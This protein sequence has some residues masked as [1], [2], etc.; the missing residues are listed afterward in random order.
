M[1]KP[2]IRAVEAFP[3]EHE[4]QRLICLRDPLGLAPQPLAM[5]AA[6]YFLL[7]LMDGTR[8][9]GEIGQA[10]AHQFGYALPP[11]QLD[12]FIETLDQ[13]FFLDNSRFAR[14]RRAVGQ[15]FAGLAQRPAAHAGLCYP[16]QPSELR[17][18]LMSFFEPP[19]GPGWAEIASKPSLPNLAGLI[20]PH[21]DPRRG[22]SAYARAYHQMMVRQPPQ[23][24]IILGTSHYGS[25]PE[26][27]TATTKDY[28]TPL[29]NL[30]TDRAF[31]ARLAGRYRAGDLFADELLHRNEHSI[32]FQ[33]LFLALTLGLEDY[34]IVPI[35]VSSFHE[36]VRDRRM[37]NADPRVGAFLD[38][39]GE[40]L[41]ADGRRVCIIAGVDFAHVGKKF[42]DAQAADDDMIAWLREED[43]RLIETIEQGDGAAFFRDILCDGDRRRI[44]GLSPIYT[45]L[46]LLRGRRGR[47]LAYD[48]AL[49]PPTESA[50][51]YAALAID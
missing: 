14:R 44:C 2:R 41:A 15:E 49:E 25:G 30:T 43:R 9:A 22:R 19:Q 46:E 26:L 6:A 33:T 34:Q 40:E 17:K 31:L 10:F 3:I 18:E 5:G 8:S 48:V 11:A 47:L 7:S 4:G 39:L 27:F 51:S 42:G 45:Q 13:G 21:I 37:P 16:A 35:L 12:A 24:V 36:L 23:L 38:A 28:A 29:G 1:D 32:E 50:V 20:A